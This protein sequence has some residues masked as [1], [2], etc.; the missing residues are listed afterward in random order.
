VGG[1]AEGVAALRDLLRNDESYSRKLPAPADARQTR[2]PRC[3]PPSLFSSRMAA[4]CWYYSP[5]SP[6]PEEYLIKLNEILLRGMEEQIYNVGFLG[7]YF[8]EIREVMGEERKG[9]KQDAYLDLLLYSEVV[10]QNIIRHEKRLLLEAEV[11]GHFEWVYTTV[12]ERV[13][14]VTEREEKH[15][16]LVYS[17]VQYLLN[18]AP[19]GRLQTV[20]GCYHRMATG[21]GAHS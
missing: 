21:K 13:T 7:R 20:I 15:I 8:S 2:P 5:F 16:K 9:L 10:L 3:V 11:Y 6:Q 18:F 12:F 1:D 14:S 19:E 4:Y 17:L